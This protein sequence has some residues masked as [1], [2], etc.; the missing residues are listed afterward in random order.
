MSLMSPPIRTSSGGSLWFWP[1]GGFAEAGV[2]AASAASSTSAVPTAISRPRIAADPL[3]PRRGCQAGAGQA[4]ARRWRRWAVRDV[5]SAFQSSSSSQCGSVVARKSAST[6]GEPLGVLEVREV[7]GARQGLEARVRDLLV[8]GAAVLERDRVVALAP[9]DHRRHGAEQVEAVGRADAL[10]AEVD[11]RAQRLQEGDPGAGMLERAQGADDRAQVLAPPRA[12]RVEPRRRPPRSRRARAGAP[13]TRP[14]P[15]RRAAPRRGA[16]GSPPGRGRR[17]R[18]APAG[19]R[20]RGTARRTASRSRRPASG[21]RTSPAARRS[22]SAG[23][24]SPPRARRSSSRRAAS[25][26]RRGRSGRARSPGGSRRGAAPPRASAAR[27][28]PSRG[29]GPR[30]DP[31]RRRGRSP[32]GREARPPRPRNPRREPGSWSAH[33]TDGPRPTRLFPQNAK[34]RIAT[35]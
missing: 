25:P 3:T 30:A 27:S 1:W 28:S 35:P 5:I 14:P 4:A 17:R 16:S 9:D 18:R 32:G 10:A 12:A 23:R 31:R 11:H 7:G 26:S 22:R 15:A 19:R 33:P 6:V 2:D 20:A 29:S 24:G 21:R 34:S 13:P 8:G